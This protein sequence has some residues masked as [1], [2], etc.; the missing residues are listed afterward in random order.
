VARFP[1]VDDEKRGGALKTF[2]TASKKKWKDVDSCQTTL[3]ESEKHQD[4]LSN[5]FKE[6]DFVEIIPRVNIKKEKAS[7]SF[8]DDPQPCHTCGHYEGQ[9]ENKRSRRP[10]KRLQYQSDDF[11]SNSGPPEEAVAEMLKTHAS[12]DAAFVFEELMQNPMEV[13]KEVAAF[14]RRRRARKLQM[15]ENKMSTIPGSGQLTITPSDGNN[16]VPKRLPLLI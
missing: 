2:V 16:Q 13:G 14:L 7:D 10:P 5:E 1:D 9:P 8:F 11:F 6:S 15:A 3:M 12:D 4:W